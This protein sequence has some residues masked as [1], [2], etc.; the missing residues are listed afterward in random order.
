MESVF[1]KRKKFSNW[2][3]LFISYKVSSPLSYQVIEKNYTEMTCGG[4]KKMFTLTSWPL[5]WAQVG[6][7]D[8][9]SKEAQA[10]K[11]GTE[12]ASRTFRNWKWWHQMIEEGE[13]TF[14]FRELLSVCAGHSV[15]GLHLTT[16]PLSRDC[17]LLTFIHL[18]ISFRK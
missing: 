11:P 1:L 12:L 16:C 14:Y 3:T 2:M 6:I 15:L 10:T 5:S 8:P 9:W 4:K 17:F 13:W 18:F 7:G